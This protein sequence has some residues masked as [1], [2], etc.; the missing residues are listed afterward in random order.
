MTEEQIPFTIESFYKFIKEGKLMGAKCSKCGKLLVPPKP[1]CPECFS[2]DLKW[3]ELP[4]QGKLLTYT[5]IHV[6]PKKFQQLTPYAVGIIELEEGT[7]LPGMMKNV[8]LDKIKVGMNLAVD[9]EKESMS[10]EWP[11]WPRYY[12]KSPHSQ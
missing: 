10:E 4:K 12:F 5:V 11:Q 7:R 3:K 1:M 6:S 8:D 2:V 9:V